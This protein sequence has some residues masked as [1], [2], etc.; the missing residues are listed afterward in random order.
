MEHE[1][2]C[3]S[4]PSVVYAA[5]DDGG[6]H[7]NFLDASYRRICADEG[8]RRRLEKAYTASRRVPRQHDRQRSELDCANSSDALLMNIFCYPGV[9][10]RAGVCRLLGVDG[11]LRPCF[12]VRALVP[13]LG[14]RVDR[15]E[16]DMELGEYLVEAKLT[17]TGFQQAPPRLVERY[18]DL[19]EVFEVEALPR[20][21]TGAYAEYQLVRG[22]LAAHARGQRFLVLC[23]GRRPAL[24]ESWFRVMQAVRSWELRDRLR[25][26]TWQELSGELPRVV[27][28]FLG[29]KYGIEAAD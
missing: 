26:L 19:R 18:C 5:A 28:A 15:T 10:R 3:G 7:G 11:G 23:D 24:V 21:A 8:W 29:E 4:V 22:V 2:T 14:G 1:V 13:M 9:T 6:S 16:I 20:T 17:E 27:R 12:G 25:L